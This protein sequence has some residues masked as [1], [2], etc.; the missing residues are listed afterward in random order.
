MSTLDLSQ[1]CSLIQQV[2]L[3]NPIY[4]RIL[5]LHPPAGPLLLQLVPTANVC[6]FKPRGFC[7][8][9]QSGSPSI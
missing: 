3:K 4:I 1:L 8:Q 2:F 6:S 5:F 7:V 9:G